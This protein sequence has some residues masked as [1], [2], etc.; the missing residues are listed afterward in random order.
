VKRGRPGI[1][2]QSFR[3]GAGQDQSLVAL[4]NVLVN[5]VILVPGGALKQ[6]PTVAEA[7]LMT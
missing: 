4:V 6:Q 3:M 5:W 2:N 7:L 1:K